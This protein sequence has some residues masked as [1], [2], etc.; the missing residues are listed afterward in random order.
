MIIEAIRKYVELSADDEAIIGRLFHQKAY[1]KGDYLLQAGTT[2]RHIFFIGTGLVRYYIVSDGEERTN[3]FNREGEFVCDY[4]SFLPQRPGGV[5]IQSLEDSVV[6][7]IGFDDMQRLYR[8]VSAGERFG[9]LAI[10][11]V[12]CQVIA[13]IASLYVDPPEVR[14][15]KFLESFPHLVSR[16]P[17]YYI[18]SYVGVKPQSL[19]RIRKRLAGR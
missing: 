5:S 19:S 14:Y 4:L 1:K 13:Q 9:R 17:Q 10:E 12:F 3:Y 2:C 11:V 7:S 18:A 16:I 15:E 6:W 8:E